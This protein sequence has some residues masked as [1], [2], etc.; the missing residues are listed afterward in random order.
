MLRKL[1]GLIERI[2]G[3]NRNSG[4]GKE[5]RRL[6]WYA[7]RKPIVA[8]LCLT[9]AVTLTPVIGGFA[10][11]TAKA[12]R[13]VSPA[14]SK[15]VESR[16]I[17]KR[18]E[19]DENFSTLSGSW[20]YKFSDFLSDKAPTK[21]TLR[22]MNGRD[23]EDDDDDLDHKDYW[24][25]LELGVIPEDWAGDSVTMAVNLTYTGKVVNEY[26][27]GYSIHEGYVELTNNDKPKVTDVNPK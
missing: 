7:V 15:T 18:Y 12:E 22:Y 1:R 20:T 17:H 26:N 8:L 16:V 11:M 21:L 25:S 6:P 2:G 9:L 5:G 13:D 24:G 10:P 3:R 23:G 14:G 19:S 27:S 4:E